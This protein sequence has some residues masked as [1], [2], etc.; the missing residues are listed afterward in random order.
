MQTELAIKVYSNTEQNLDAIAAKFADDLK[1]LDVK[2]GIDFSKNK[3]VV[4]DVDGDDAEFAIHFLKEKYG[5]PVYEPVAGKKYRGYIQSIKEDKIV[6]DIGKKF[7]ITAN[8]LKNLGTGSP[9]QVAT[10]FGLIPYMPVKVEIVKTNEGEQVRFTGQQVDK[11]WE[12][13]KSSTDRI[14]VNSVTR[15]QL[16]SVLKK[17][18]H[19]RDIYGTER[20]GIMEHCVIC[21]ENT[22]GPG[23]VA[24]IGPKLNADM[25]VIR[26]EK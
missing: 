7:S 14:I 17:T 24:E 8:G 11:L 25:G 3:W 6:V 21:R 2:L 16:K 1:D 5:T 9:D 12:W 22:D 15:S 26:S 19:S 18:G 23:I 10:R 13:K 20:L 4:V